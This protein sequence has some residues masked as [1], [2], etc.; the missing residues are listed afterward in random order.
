MKR[1]MYPLSLLLNR[2]QAF[3]RICSLVASDGGGAAASGAPYRGGARLSRL[4]SSGSGEARA[5]GGQCAEPAAHKGGKHTRAL[6]ASGCRCVW[7]AGAAPP[8]DA[9]CEQWQ[10]PAVTRRPSSSPAGTAEPMV[11]RQ[12]QFLNRRPS[13]RPVGTADNQSPFA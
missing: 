12:A 10:K 3:S 9:R 11:L 4:G 8:A 6:A 5:R 2:I 7:P 13:S 1:Q